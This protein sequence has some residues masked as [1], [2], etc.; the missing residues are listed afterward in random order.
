MW[1]DRLV[2]AESFQG[3]PIQ[4]AGHRIT[5]NRPDYD[6]SGSVR[7]SAQIRRNGQ[8]WPATLYFLTLLDHDGLPQE[9]PI[10]IDMTVLAG[11]ETAAL[12]VEFLY[13][14]DDEPGSIQLNAESMDP[15]SDRVFGEGRFSI[16]G[17]L[18]VDERLA[19]YASLVSM[20]F[21]RVVEKYS[22]SQFRDEIKTSYELRLR[23]RSRNTALLGNLRLRL[24]DAAGVE[25]DSTSLEGPKPTTNTYEWLMSARCW[26]V[27]TQPAQAELVLELPPVDDWQPVK[28]LG[29]RRAA[30]TVRGVSCRRHADFTYPKLTLIQVDGELAAS[31]GF[32]TGAIVRATVKDES[33]RVIGSAASELKPSNTDALPFQLAITCYRHELPD[34]VFLSVDAPE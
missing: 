2:I 27:R 15:G 24:L 18:R 6:G 23:L 16:P 4:L 17:L 9:D 26:D 21:E 29:D 34:T 33:G 8:D 19:K 22:V 31:G 20:R 12:F 25:V 11:G 10:E 14:V 32:P 3:L 28:I 7:F 5:A 30:R 1:S 13:E